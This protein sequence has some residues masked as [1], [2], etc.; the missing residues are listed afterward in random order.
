MEDLI[1]KHDQ[2]KLTVTKTLE[3]KLEE[4]EQKIN[5]YEARLN[6]LE[7]NSG[8]QQKELEKNFQ[9][10]IDEMNRRHD[11]EMS[12]QENKMDTLDSNIETLNQFK[13]TKAIREENLRKEGERY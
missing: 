7:L 3:T 9:G 13:D 11:V 4:K 6:E 1:L 2:E 10:K 8:K 12:R 5:K